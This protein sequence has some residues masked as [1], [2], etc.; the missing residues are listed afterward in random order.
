V[1][2]EFRVKREN[3]VLLDSPDLKVLVDYRVILDYKANRD[4]QEQ[5][6]RMVKKDPLDILVFKEYR[7]YRVKEVKM[8]YRE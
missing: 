4:L 2:L 5:R 8:D 7:D 6:V 3:R 1:T